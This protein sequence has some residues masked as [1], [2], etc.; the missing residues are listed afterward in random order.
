[1]VHGRWWDL[2]VGGEISAYLAH[3]VG[4]KPKI[5]AVTWGFLH[6]PNLRLGQPEHG[7]PDETQTKL[8]HVPPHV[9]Q[10][11]MTKTKQ[12]FEKTLKKL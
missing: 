7:T 9:Q 11:T 6:L 12:N 3:V 8:I 2:R 10:R 1:M 4:R 5:G